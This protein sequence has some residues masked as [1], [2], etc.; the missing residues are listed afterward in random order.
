MMAA[1]LAVAE[2]EMRVEAV[3][4]G[5][6]FAA[7]EPMGEWFLPIEDFGEGL[8]P[9]QLSG[10]M[11]PEFFEIGGGFVP[12]LFV[13]GEGFYLGFGG[14]LGRGGKEAGFLHDGIELA[15]LSLRH[16]KLPTDG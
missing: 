5:V 13:V 9:V 2:C 1:L 3:V 7:D 15:S 14:E 16:D 8:E 6:G 12:E 10:E 4:R 11:A